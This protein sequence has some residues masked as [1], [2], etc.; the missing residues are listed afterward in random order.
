MSLA[1]CVFDLDGVVVDTAWS[2][3][4][5]W[6]RLAGELGFDLS[7]EQNERLKGISRRASLEIVLQLGG[8]ELPERE[9]ERLAA[10]KNAWYLEEVE[11]LSQADT[12]PGFLPLLEHVERCGLLTA[13]ASA[14]CNAALI[15]GRLGLAGRFN[16]VVDGHR[17]RN[18]KP[19]PEIFLTAAADLRLPP[20]RC[21]VIEDGAAGV[22]AAH[23]AGMACVGV[24]DPSLLHEADVVVRSLAEVDP[25]SLLERCEAAAPARANS[26]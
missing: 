2:H 15:L 11:R 17:V 24:G 12:L 5:A 10:R 3:Y 16:C 9:K 13:V 14:S 6:R 25:G 26:A 4:A 8:L 23:A 21:L 18:T 1:A 22:A 20:E 7:P 19:H